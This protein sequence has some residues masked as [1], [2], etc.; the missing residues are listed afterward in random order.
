MIPD[1]PKGLDLGPRTGR[2]TELEYRTADLFLHDISQTGRL[3]G[4]R[5]CLA[6][7]TWL[8]RGAEDSSHPLLP[9]SLR[10]DEEN[11]PVGAATLL[12]TP[13]ELWT[14]I[15][16]AGVEVAHKKGTEIP[17]TNRRQYELERRV[18]CT[19]FYGADLQGL[20][21]PEDSQRL[22]G[23]LEADPTADWPPQELLSL[24]ALAQHH[25]CPTRLLD[26]SCDGRIAAW[27]AA[28]GALGFKERGRPNYPPPQ[29]SPDR[30]LA[31]WALDTGELRFNK[32]EGRRDD[33]RQYTLEL[34]T[35]PG[36]GNPNLHAQK[37]FFTL[38]RD[39]K[40]HLRK[41]IKRRGIDE[42][43]C[44]WSQRDRPEHATVLKLTLPWSQ[45]RR[46]FT[47]LNSLCVMSATLF[48]GY[49]G[50][51]DSLWECRLRM[52]DD[53]LKKTSPET[54]VLNEDPRGPASH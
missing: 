14:H 1:L 28:A 12:L 31:V 42:V 17:K 29:C 20:G 13:C 36:S 47:L 52:T 50:V 46:L 26:W 3:F 44:R 43:I 40:A 18:L 21:L 15:V 30:K 38:M 32:G 37:G 8:F 10:V 23:H 25:G 45:A 27:F 16:G 54:A 4:P 49:A 35:A 41:K 2:Y 5:G 6:H 24:L 22:R 39:R 11:E 9:S 53:E 34:I 51:A 33:T 7:S 19:F 48:P